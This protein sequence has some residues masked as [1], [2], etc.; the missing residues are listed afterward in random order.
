M[1][2]IPVCSCTRDRRKARVFMHFDRSGTGS[3]QRRR[4]QRT[5]RHSLKGRELTCLCLYLLELVAVMASVSA[6]SLMSLATEKTP[7]KSEGR[8]LKIGK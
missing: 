8:K 3:A 4:G 6:P 7:K 5:L 1:A 2:L